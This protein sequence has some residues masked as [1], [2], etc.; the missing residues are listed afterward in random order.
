MD[1]TRM[2]GLDI[3]FNPCFGGWVFE[4]MAMESLLKMAAEVSI[5]VLV[6]GSLRLFA[7]TLTAPIIEFQSLFWW[8]GL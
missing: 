7:G 1:F 8:M 6:D 2:S 4:T 5:L 3:S